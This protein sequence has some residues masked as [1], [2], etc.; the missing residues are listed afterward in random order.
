MDSNQ[1]SPEFVT[2]KVPAEFADQL[3]ETVRLRGMTVAGAFRA[4]GERFIA[5][6]NSV[7]PRRKK[8]RAA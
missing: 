5:L 4:H 3:R 1:K 7:Q 2:I 8:A 6:I